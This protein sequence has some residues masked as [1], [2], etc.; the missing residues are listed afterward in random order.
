M[1]HKQNQR[2]IIRQH[3]SQPS[4]RQK[5]LLFIHFFFIVSLIFHPRL[6]DFL[7]VWDYI[8]GAPA[9]ITCH[10]CIITKRVVWGKGLGLN[11]LS[12]GR[13]HRQSLR[14]LSGA[15]VWGLLKQHRPLA[16]AV[17]GNGLGLTIQSTGHLAP[18]IA[19]S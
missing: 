12:T 14:A 5:F 19:L 1:I 6:P 13:L 16:P 7:A 10:R 2:K 17:W 11:L 4:H 3:H 9:G 15:T 8:D 18:A